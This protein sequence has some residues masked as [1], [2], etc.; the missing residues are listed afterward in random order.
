MI[1]VVRYGILENR[2]NS[3]NSALFLIKNSVK[4]FEEYQAEVYAEYLKL[5]GTSIVLANPTPSSLRDEALTFHKNGR[6]GA[7]V[8]RFFTSSGEQNGKLDID[9]F[10][11]AQNFLIGKTNEP[12]I[13]VVEFVAWFID[14]EPRPFENW[15]NARR[16]NLEAE[17]INTETDDTAND[18]K[19]IE[20]PSTI[21]DAAAASVVQGNPPIKL[22][23]EPQKQ[24]KKLNFIQRTGIVATLGLIMG[25]TYWKGIPPD[26]C[27]YWTG[28]EY[29]AV[30]CDAQLPNT[31]ILALNQ[32]KLEHFKKITLPDTMTFNSLNR[33]WYSKINNEVEFFTTKGKHPL[34]TDRTLK[35]ITTHI[36]GKYGNN[37]IQSFIKTNAADT[38]EKD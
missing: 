33:V 13:K 27:M 29:K 36:L 2:K 38:A 30:D 18:G 21:E 3:R 32:Q 26:G 5:K 34:K 16:D 15:R 10:R 20:V 35:P 12:T 11:P 8:L 19:E 22:I 28:T 23:S 24:I 31:Q 1:P 14:F 9:K 6:E 7:D 37:R 4:M 17:K 25:V